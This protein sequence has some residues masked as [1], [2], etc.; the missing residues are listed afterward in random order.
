MKKITAAILLSFNSLF[1]FAPVNSQVLIFLPDYPQSYFRDPLGIPI[2]LAANFGEL[3]PNHFHMGLDIRTNQRENLP[4]YA[5]AKGYVSKIKIEKSGFGHAIYINH[6]NGYTTLY[7]HLNK[8]YDPLEDF[9]TAKQYA[10]QQWEQ[11]VDFEPNQFPVEKGQLIAYSGNTGGSEGPHLHFEIRDTKT[12]NN[13]NPWIFGMGLTDKMPPTIYKLYYYDRRYSTYQ[14]KPLPIPIVGDRAKYTSKQSVVTLTSPVVSFGISAE[15]KIHISSFKYGIY[16]T[17]LSIDGIKR[18]G[19][20]LNN[21]SYDD[22][23]YVNGSIDYK[24]RASGGPYIQHLSR[25][26]G[27]HSTIFS[28]AA[29]GKIVLADTLIHT[30]EILV[31]DAVGN[32]STLTFKFRWSPSTTDDLVFPQNSIN[33]APGKANTLQM[34]DIEAD[35]SPKAFYDTVPFVYSAEL[36]KDTKVV[37]AIHHLHNFTVPVHDSFMVRIK[38]TALIPDNLKD[39]IVMQLISNHKIEAVKGQWKEGWMEA[40][41]RDLGLVKLLID[42]IPPRVAIAGWTNGANLRNKKSIAI[43][44]SDNVDDVK[45]FTAFLDGNWL[46]FSR[47]NNT[48]THLFDKRTGPGK[49]ELVVEV[50]D[51]AGNVTER[52]YTFTR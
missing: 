25:L 9:V 33:M 50:E 4:V 40:K 6:P 31:K 48:F 35:F 8:F 52:T 16:E 39:R 22:T 1:S 30:A 28:T 49:H 5:A 13:L 29:D 18:S 7:A 41:F 43:A 46:M 14:V 44:T 42:T 32:T 2:S 26:P 36:S 12:G 45:S 23:R 21:I 34:D 10:D 19:F 3:R 38:P 47:K 37:S 11:E 15:D 51:E 20:A 24:T 27:N 17:A